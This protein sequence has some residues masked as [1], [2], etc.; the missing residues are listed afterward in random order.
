MKN[1]IMSSAENE[2]N[3]CSES[4]VDEIERIVDGYAFDVLQ[5][6]CGDYTED[7]DKCVKL[8][9]KTP[10]KLSTQKRTKSMLPPFINILNSVP[11]Q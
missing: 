11:P 6:L 8:L 1:C 3:V 10:K 7:S 4:N 2:K 9:P 5:L